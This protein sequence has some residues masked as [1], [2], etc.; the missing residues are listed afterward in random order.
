MITI[1]P[2]ELDLVGAYTDLAYLDGGDQSWDLCAS[3]VA[4]FFNMPA[5][6]DRTGFKIWLK[7]YKTP[8]PDRV[9][10]HLDDAEE[11]VTGFYVTTMWVD[12]ELV[13]F[14]GPVILA[15]KAIF[16]KLKATKLYVEV[17]Y[18]A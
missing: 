6:A 9:E 4:D 16:K 1:G 18:E 2:L 8:A 12:D 15:A 7:V 13:E 11:V 14:Y 5:D 17:E 3:R 10:V